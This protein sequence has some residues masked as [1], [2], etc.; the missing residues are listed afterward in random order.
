MAEAGESKRQTRGIYAVVSIGFVLMFAAAWRWWDLRV[1]FT[2]CAYTLFLILY[3]DR[4]QI[5]HNRFAEFMTQGFPLLASRLDLSLLRV[6]QVY[7][8]GFVLFY[9]AVFAV[10]AFVLKDRFMAVA[11]FL[12]CVLM[13]T[14]TFFYPPGQLTHGIAWMLLGCAMFRYVET[15]WWTAPIVYL[16]MFAAAFSIYSVVV[17]ARRFHGL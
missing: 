5:Q 17:I 3:E 9:A 6:A 15:A 10:I 4:L 1:A 8:A 12:L 13:T 2:D 11:V 16:V 14:D 7:S